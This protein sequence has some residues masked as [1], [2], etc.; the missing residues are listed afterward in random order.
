[1]STFSTTRTPKTRT[2][3]P[4]RQKPVSTPMAETCFQKVV[5]KHEAEISPVR[6][7]KRMAGTHTADLIRAWRKD[8]DKT[9][10][11]LHEIGKQLTLIASRLDKL[12]NDLSEI[13]KEKTELD[14][15]S[16]KADLI[17]SVK[18]FAQNGKDSM[19]KL[20]EC[21]APVIEDLSDSPIFIR[22]FDDSV[23]KI[24]SVFSEFNQCMDRDGLF[25]RAGVAYI[26]RN[27]DGEKIHS[28]AKFGKTM[29]KINEE[30]LVARADLARFKRRCL[31]AHSA[32]ALNQLEQALKAATDMA[33]KSSNCVQKIGATLY[34]LAAARQN[35][36]APQ[37]PT[38]QKPGNGL[39]WNMQDS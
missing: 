15:K 7:F 32:A 38:G 25:E 16:E 21:S 23:L 22:E 14:L 6:F 30:L 28:L 20:S 12:K 29:Q 31:T 27:S 3:K 8:L 17:D 36:H 26:N 24:K 1:M 33:V 2:P 10:G 13:G 11:D 35:S 18:F 39:G 9:D 37:G 4:V 5:R 19:D 34:Y